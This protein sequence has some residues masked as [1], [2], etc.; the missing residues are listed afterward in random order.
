MQFV[1]VSFDCLPPFLLIWTMDV[2]IE[3]NELSNSPVHPI[4]NSN[5]FS[6]FIVSSC[7]SLMKTIYIV[8]V[9]RVHVL[10]TRL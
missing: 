8:K 9:V 7:N 6:L 5:V 10:H 3:L 1:H 4:C 2:H